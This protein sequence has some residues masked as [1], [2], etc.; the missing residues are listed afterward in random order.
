C[1]CMH[2][3]LQPAFRDARV[4][5]AFAE[6]IDR[7]EIV[8]VASHGLWTRADGMLPPG[9]PGQNPAIRRIPYD[10]AGARRL[11]SE[12]G[13]AGGRGFP[14]LTLVYTRSQPERSAAAQIIRQRLQQNLG[15]TISLLEK[16]AAIFVQ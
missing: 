15:V 1:I 6:A 12:A 10:P 14:S 2:P 16:E 11:L 13:F 4:R 3:R 7:D 5:R 9:M 8:R